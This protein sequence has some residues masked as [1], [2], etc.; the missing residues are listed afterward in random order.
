MPKSNNNHDNK[1]YIEKEIQF[2]FEI[3]SCHNEVDKNDICPVCLCFFFKEK[4]VYNVNTS[5]V[6]FVPFFF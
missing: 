5:L 2:G 1:Q 6:I 3:V 4:N